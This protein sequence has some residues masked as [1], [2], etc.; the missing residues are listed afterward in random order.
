MHPLS[1]VLAST[2]LNEIESAAVA[3]A[4]QGRPSR[5]R[6]LRARFAARRGPASPPSYGPRRTVGAGRA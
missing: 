1:T 4:Q 3:H 2:V 6:G 5:R